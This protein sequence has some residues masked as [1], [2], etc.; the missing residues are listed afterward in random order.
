ML[1][2]IQTLSREREWV[3]EKLPINCYNIIASLL[4]PRGKFVF[5]MKIFPQRPASR[6]GRVE[7]HPI[8][9]FSIDAMHPS[10]L[11]L[12]RH[13]VDVPRELTN[14]NEIPRLKV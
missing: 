4:D 10:N 7:P 2:A 8:C 5:N 6:E 13:M 12:L 3:V 9:P 14:T 11:K 1:Y